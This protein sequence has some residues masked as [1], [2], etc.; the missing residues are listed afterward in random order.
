MSDRKWWD[1]YECF[2][3]LQDPQQRP[4]SD[5][6]LT[7]PFIAGELDCKPIKDLLLEYRAEV[8]EEE[9]VDEEA[10][11]CM[12]FLFSLSTYDHFS[13]CIFMLLLII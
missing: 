10:E 2:P 9:L 6:L 1:F 4:S 11:V 7:L 13:D 12:I 5:I 8:V 3:Q